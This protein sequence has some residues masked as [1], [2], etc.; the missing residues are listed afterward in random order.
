MD[1]PLRKWD[2]DDVWYKYKININRLDETKLF[3]NI[4]I[5]GL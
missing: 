2:S 1:Y 3:I 4:L 5:L